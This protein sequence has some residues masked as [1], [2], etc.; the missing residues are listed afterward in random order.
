MR[1]ILRF[2]WMI[3]HDIIDDNVKEML[4][5]AFL[6]VTVLMMK[7]QTNETA[8]AAQLFLHVAL[9][10][11]ET[12]YGVTMMTMCV[13]R[14]LLYFQVTCNFLKL[15]RRISYCTLSYSPYGGGRYQH[16]LDGG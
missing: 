4:H 12:L 3:F 2:G 14:S 6:G 13:F 9:V 5:F 7:K 15:G 16:E 11:I 8:A 1:F 10:K